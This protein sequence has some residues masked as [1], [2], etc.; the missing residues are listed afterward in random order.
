MKKECNIYIKVNDDGDPSIDKEPTF[1][2]KYELKNL[3]GADIMV[4][5][6]ALNQVQR[7]LLEKLVEFDKYSEK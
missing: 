1:N 2:Y 3:D 5:H 6:C 4:A 7:E